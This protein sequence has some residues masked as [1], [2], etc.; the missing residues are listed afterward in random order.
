[1]SRLAGWVAHEINNPLAGMQNAFTLVQGLIP[2][3]H[4]HHKYVAAIERELARVAAFT[5]RLQQTYRY[6]DGR[7][8]AMSLARFIAD[9][10]HALDPL[11][12][13]R[14][15]T[16]QVDIQPS[17]SGQ[18]VSGLL[19]RAAIRHLVQHAI[20]GAPPGDVIRIAVWSDANHLW[21]SVPKYELPEI[22]SRRA[23]AGP[24]GLA[25]QLAQ[26][27]TMVLGGITDTADDGTDTA[28]LR[29]GFP[30][31]LDTKDTA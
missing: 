9:A 24:P 4:P 7:T 21:V 30:L 6:T 27:F 18:M 16:M 11:H 25:L 22:A 26:R 2:T 13:A 29:I 8:T 19:L 5:L 3:D 12:A 15:V 31:P 20:E 23:T 1:M 10:I 14:N 28:V 17:A